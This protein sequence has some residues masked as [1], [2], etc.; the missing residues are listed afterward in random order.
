[1]ICVR[2]PLEKKIQQIQGWVFD[3]IFNPIILKDPTGR[4][5]YSPADL[6]DFWASDN[7]GLKYYFLLFLN[8]LELPVPI[9]DQISAQIIVL[10]FSFHLLSR[11]GDVLVSYRADNIKKGNKVKCST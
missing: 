3:T 10:L 8:N 9:S 5:V 6:F 2:L 7:L 1:M 11:V 4:Q